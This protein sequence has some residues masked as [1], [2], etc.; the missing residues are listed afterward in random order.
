MRRIYGFFV[1][2]SMVLVGVLTAG[3]PKEPTVLQLS[4]SSHDFGTKETEF[5]FF[6]WVTGGRSRATF[7]CKSDQSWIEV[8]PAR[9][10]ATQ[11][12]NANEIV[13]T[14]D[15]GEFDSGTYEGTITVSSI[16]LEPKTFT[17][18]AKVGVPKIALLETAHDFGFQETQWSFDVWNGGDR[19]TTLEFTVAPDVDWLSVDPENGTST[20]SEDL[21]TI[22]VTLHRD[23]LEKASYSGIITVTSQ[24][25]EEKTIA[26]TA[27]DPVPAIGLTE[28]SHN[29]G[30]A[31]I[32]WS[33]EVYNAGETGSVLDFSLSSDADWL[34]IAP[35]TGVSEGIDDAQTIQVTVSRD[36]LEPGEIYQEEITVSAPGAG[37]QTVGIVLEVAEPAL[38]VSPK[39]LDFGAI[40]T[41]RTFQVWNPGQA[42]S[43]LGYYSAAPS[44]PW[45]T[46]AP[47]SGSIVADA[48]PDTVTV[49]IDRATMAKAAQ[50]KAFEASRSSVGSGAD[51]IDVV[52]VGGTPREMGVSLGELMAEEIAANLDSYLAFATGAGFDTA[53]L[54]AAWAKVSPFVDPQFIEEMEGLAEGLA[55]RNN[56]NRFQDLVRLHMV[57]VVD[58]F[59]CS[60][61]AVWGQASQDG[62]LY[63]IRNLDWELETGVQDHPWIV[64]Y[65]PDDGI[66][67]AN[68]GFAGMLG[69]ITGINAKGI[70]LSEV[71][72]SPSSEAPYD[73]NGEHFSTMFRKILYDADNLTEAV[74]IL[75]GTQ[76]IKRYHY[77][78]G[79]GRNER[80]A[81]KI[82][83]HAPDDL[84][85]Y[86]DDDPN[87]PVREEGLSTY[88]DAVYF[89]GSRNP[90]ANDHLS[91][92][93][94]TYNAAK[95]VALS[96]EVAMDGLSVLNAVYDAT[97]LEMWVA[98]AEGPDSEA[99]EREYVYVDL[100]QYF[101]LPTETEG[102]IEVTS[103]IGDSEVKE[104]IQ[105][106]ARTPE[107]A[108]G[109]SANAHDFGLESDPWKFEVWNAGD[110]GTTLNFEAAAAPAAWV[111]ITPSSGSSTGP[112][113]KVTITVEIDRDSLEKTITHE[114]AVTISAG[115]D[116]TQDVRILARYPEPEIA[117]SRAELDFG[118]NENELTFSVWNGGDAGSELDFNIASPDTWISS[119]TP[120]SGSST[121]ADDQTDI[122]V[123]IDRN[124]L[125]GIEGTTTGILTFTSSSA[126]TVT[127]P[128]SLEMTPPGPGFTASPTSVDV[129]KQV[130]FTDSSTAGSGEVVEWEWDFG[131]ESEPLI[132]TDPPKLPVEVTHEYE[133]YGVYSVTLTI[134]S[135]YGLEESI[136]QTDYIRVE[137]QPATAQFA[138]SDT[139]PDM[140]QVVNF[141]DKSDPGSGVITSWKWDLGDG[142]TSTSQNVVHTYYSHGEFTVT[143]TITTT[144]QPTGIPPVTKTITV[145]QVLPDAEFS[146]DKKIV[147]TE[148]DP[149]TFT[150]LST[151]PAPWSERIATWSAWDG[152]ID[153]MPTP[154]Q[155]NYS[156]DYWTGTYEAD[157]TD[158]LYYYFFDRGPYTCRLIE[159]SKYQSDNADPDDDPNWYSNSEVKDSYIEVRVPSPLDIYCKLDDG[160]YMAYLKDEGIEKIKRTSNGQE[161]TLYVVKMRSQEWVLNE[162]GP[163]LPADNAI[164]EHWLS[165]IVPGNYQSENRTAVLYVEGGNNDDLKPTATDPY[166]LEY[167]LQTGHVVAAVHQVPN[168]PISFTG[169]GSLSGHDMIAYSFA[170]S[171]DTGDTFW[172]AVFPMAKSVVKAMTAVQEFLNG[173]VEGPY[174]PPE[175]PIVIT[176]F[177]LA[178]ADIQAWAVWLAGAHDERVRGLMPMAF[179][180]ID[181][182]EQIGYQAGPFDDPGTPWLEFSEAWAPYTA[183]QFDAFD[184]IH[185]PGDGPVP[186]YRL[187]RAFKMKQYRKRFEMHMRDVMRDRNTHASYE[188]SNN[189]LW[190]LSRFMLGRPDTPCGVDPYYWAGAYPDLATFLASTLDSPANDGFPPPPEL[191]YLTYSSAVISAALYLDCP[192]YSPQNNPN[193]RL[194]TGVEKPL[195][196]GSAFGMDLVIEGML[197]YEKARYYE[198]MD[199][200]LAAM[201]DP[202]FYGERYGASTYWYAERGGRLGIPKCIISSPGSAYYVPTSVQLW[203]GDMNGQNYFRYIPNTDHY[204]DRTGD[205]NQNDY[206]DAFLSALPWFREFLAANGNPVVPFRWSALI[207]GDFSEYQITL[208]WL[209]EASIP[210]DLA[211]GIRLWTALDWENDFRL[212]PDFRPDGPAWKLTPINIP[213]DDEPGRYVMPV[214]QDN[215]RHKAFFFEITYTNP[216]G[217]L[218]KYTSPGY[219]CP[220]KYP[221]QRP[222]PEA[223]F[224]A[225]P[226]TAAVGEPIQF[227]DLSWDPGDDGLDPITSWYWDFGDGTTSTQPDPVHSYAGT[228]QYTVQL[229]VT[230][231][232]G[233]S[234]TI[235][236]NDITVN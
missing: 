87:D 52:V 184:R 161:Y 224:E 44:D 178:G 78:F 18:R 121:G 48:D 201:V 15:R 143:L 85:I 172:P 61:I 23:L 67:H 153:N 181:I 118:E 182:S 185:D 140:F 110:A 187:N 221:G 7:N 204:L 170:Q 134:R 129:L 98:F 190:Y 155:A 116:Q 1:L 57:P 38:A 229:T 166:L 94:G 89:A 114:G 60:A 139:T 137:P 88:N 113:D 56:P 217:E 227:S 64:V 123:T 65:H 79:D 12:N 19:G 46:V 66:P 141:T 69:C 183:A 174:S 122:T 24:R 74:D 208:E 108:I 71:G 200:W 45:I 205:E 149:V 31:E 120:A 16:G 195:F 27:R 102:T 92:N 163:S 14:I 82:K 125:A 2:V 138:V 41:E 49:T 104:T 99:Y 59:S 62:H 177:V 131:D 211:E 17:V 68:V 180:L 20:D 33:F 107:P 40:D 100:H 8:K 150:D 126:E 54:D 197:D 168:Q 148:I 228:G 214:Q 225:V 179:D 157:I 159:R 106:R 191:G 142:T 93:H 128:V 209:D 223:D 75:K 6:V 215:Y 5:S 175:I 212:D 173:D 210:T 193:T 43:V 42:G 176:D 233:P 36:S 192:K 133:S 164:W 226:R 21:Q 156:G 80:K 169:E 10:I 151:I 117:T 196:S 86:T 154:Y 234:T 84:I 203:L 103:S 213:P 194:V 81:Y 145:G 35:A 95:M 91:Q 186:Y 53:Q 147:Y 202:A 220:P 37:E 109:V 171:M 58:S 198:N 73:I 207:E 230:N 231:A 146:V 135:E 26:I 124:V 130:L 222:L 13:V 97:S 152:N 63:Q 72:N 47:A 25:G 4:H 188:T 11:A 55:N 3:C 105:V 235:K 70:A 119:I 236:E 9:G 218:V 132:V 77:V 34:S 90:I 165:I 30:T 111:S 39:V 101:D 22:N 136:T 115:P 83:A 167:A 216:F 144:F 127:M 189:R 206:K 232:I 158:G 199:G 32:T 96:R 162:T 50:T 28:T 51:R 112:S 219:W 160:T 29:F 76:R